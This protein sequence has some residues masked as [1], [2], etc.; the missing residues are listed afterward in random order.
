M[1]GPAANAGCRAPTGSSLMSRVHAATRPD[2]PNPR[3]V[4]MVVHEINHAAWA[5]H[6][7]ALENGKLAAS[8]PPQ[9]VLIGQGPLGAL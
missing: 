3:R 2:A 8:S 4:I 7:V 5:D 9:V 1:H 6:V